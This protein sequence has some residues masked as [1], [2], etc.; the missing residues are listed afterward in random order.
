MEK[1]VDLE[2][3]YKLYMND[4]FHYVFSLT[5]NQQWAEDVVQETFYRAYIYLETYNG[6]KIKPWLFKVAYNTFVDML[7]KNKRLVYLEEGTIDLDPN[8]E[9]KSA[10][11]E[12]LLREEINDWFV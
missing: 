3:I 8:R 2:E 4:L 11:D 7:R 10:E 5:K 12:F 1:K 6:E 9:A